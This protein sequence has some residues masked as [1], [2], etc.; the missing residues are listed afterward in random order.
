MR[1]LPPTSSIVLGMLLTGALGAAG[2]LANDARVAAAEPD[3]TSPPVAAAVESLFRENCIDC[4]SGP[5]REA[6]LDLSTPAGILHGGES[7]PVIVPGKPDES[8]LFKK[9]QHG[10]MPPE[11]QDDLA[12][13][14]VELL[15]AWI[16]NGAE[17]GGRNDE[18]RTTDPA[19]SQHDVIPIFLRRCTV[20]HG[21]RR[22]EGGLDLSTKA[23]ILRGG[24]S[25]PA[26]TPGK[27]DDSLII[28]KTRAGLMPPP[29]RLV[30]V[31]VKPIEQA[32]IDILASW[33]AAGAPEVEIEPDVADSTPDPLVTED[34]RNFWSFRPPL[35]VNVPTVRHD[36][37]VKNPIDAFVLQKLEEQGVSLAPEANRLT[38]LRRACFD[39]TG[40]PPTPKEIESFLA[41]TAPD[42]YERLIDRLLA[43]SRYGERWGRFWLD[44]AGYAD[45]EGKR[46][47]DLPRPH[48]WR[49]RDYV[50]R[51]LNDDKPFDRFL[52]E[53]LAGDELADY[54][55]APE[56]TPAMYDNLVATGFLRMVPDGTWANIT[57]YV[58]DRIEVI[59]DEIDVLG[60]AVLGLTLKCARCHS[61]KF[62]PI[63]I[64]DYYRLLD[65]FKGA[66]DEYDWLKPDVKS[67][68]GP[69]SQDTREGRLMPF[70]T[71]A[72]AQAWQAHEAQVNEEVA[73]LQSA[74]DVKEREL[75]APLLEERIL[76]LPADEQ[77]SVRAMLATPADERNATQIE[78]AKRYE[79]ELRFDRE[80][81]KQLNTDFR[82]LCEQS[83]AQVQQAQ[84][85]RLPE[86][87]IQALWDRGAPSPTYIYR[88]GDPQSPGRLVGPGVPSVLTDGKT[89]FVVKPPRPDG[90]STGRRLALANWLVSPEHPLTAR[91]AVNRIWKQHFGDGLVKTLANFGRAG[92]PPTHPELLD[93]LAVEFVRQGWSQ[94][95]MHRLMMSSATYRQTSAVTDDHERIDPENSLL[96][97]MPLSR[98][99]AEALYDSLLFV[100][101]RLDDTPFGPAD[102]VEVRADGLVT[103]K[104]T[105]RGWRRLVYV[106]QLRK[107]PLTHRESF[108][109]PQMNPN[110]VE[111]R[112]SMVAPQALYLMNSGMVYQLAESFAARVLQ[113]AGTEPAAQIKRIFLV[114]VGRPPSDEESQIGIEALRLLVESWESSSSAQPDGS[115]DVHRKALA[116]YCHSIMNSAEFLFVD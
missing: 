20:C 105:G 85:K 111:R 8:L 65:V 88:R 19:H 53:Q 15:R 114:A 14:Q 58:P 46:E 93:W 16:E 40:L 68:L 45:S 115:D 22:Q 54:E 86:P 92:T 108:D 91:V 30:E 109:F 98:L 6:E 31:S 3:S 51:S 2:A 95:A 49:Y 76:K 50:I 64:R 24:K 80:T 90:A 82:S 55:H 72:E 5:A 89:P 113:E 83:D 33:I 84:A 21:L 35:P 101:G 78:L 57:G 59:A 7:G 103:P 77:A 39:L 94:K 38:L 56:I 29:D 79:S 96:S 4:H 47:Q 41:D 52:V 61:H 71:T 62:D 81:L 23:A 73:V 100:A 17:M 36:Q 44:L 60:S 99:D 28:Q 116:A 48:A 26:I 42:S 106:Q 112:E 18:S 70:V 13:E 1:S 87:R 97:R 9:V 110:C 25:G 10:E 75:A 67:G 104:D 69:V 12:P 107:Q 43:S 27:P 34:D 102:P 66:L 74:L 63:P 37:Q 32:E 11:G